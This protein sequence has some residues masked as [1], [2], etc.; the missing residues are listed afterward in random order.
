MTDASRLDASLR[1]LR[2]EVASLDI[3]D[4]DARR[5][6]AALVGDLEDAVADPARTGERKTLGEQLRASILRVEAAHPRLAGV[7]N[8]V[9]DLLGNMGI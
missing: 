4:D 1:R 3:G 2:A 8:E 5:R 9:V 7:V 6:L